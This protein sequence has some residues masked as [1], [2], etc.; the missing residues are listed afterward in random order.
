MMMSFQ[1]EFI[2]RKIL[3]S[4]KIEENWK[5]FVFDVWKINI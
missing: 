1:F 5:H 2:G 4:G 3:I